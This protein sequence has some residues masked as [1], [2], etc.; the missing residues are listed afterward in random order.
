MQPFASVEDYRTRYPSDET[1][2]AVLLEVLMEATD[3][4]SAELDACGIDYASPSESL[5]FRL[6]RVCRTVAH[7]A[8]GDGD[9]GRDVPFGAT[10]LSETSDAFSASVQL[11]NPYGDLFLTEAERRSLGVG[12]LASCVSSAYAW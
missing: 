7:R 3:L 11:A 5:A 4:M 6:A 2:D 9:G 10:Q 8:I 1:E 12:Q